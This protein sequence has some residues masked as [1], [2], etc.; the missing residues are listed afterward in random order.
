MH[1]SIQYN[2]ADR[3]LYRA[4]DI[5]V[6][7]GQRSPSIILVHVIHSRQHFRSTEPL[8]CIYDRPILT[9]EV[10]EEKTSGAW[11]VETEKEKKQAV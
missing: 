11:L 3:Q 9:V 5:N 2:T 8:F 4:V 7:F 10:N 6:Q 1:L